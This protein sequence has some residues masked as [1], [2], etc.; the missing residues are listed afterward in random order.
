MIKQSILVLCSVFMSTACTST[1]VSYPPVEGPVEPISSYMVRDTSIVFI[2][3]STGCTQDNSFGLRVMNDNSKPQNVAVIRTVADHCR[4]APFNGRFEVQI[5]A[6][7]QGEEL[8][9]TNT[10]IPI[11]K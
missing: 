2:T 6:S 10:I 4:R 1:E 7:L 8:N 11:E 5:P 3:Q 9:I